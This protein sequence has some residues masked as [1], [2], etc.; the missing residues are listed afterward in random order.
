MTENY[1]YII[2]NL[3]P[4]CFAFKGTI[5]TQRAQENHRNTLKSFSHF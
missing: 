3:Y 1:N 4:E 2:I 5:S